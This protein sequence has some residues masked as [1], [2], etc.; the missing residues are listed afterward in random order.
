[1]DRAGLKPSQM[2]LTKSSSRSP[3]GTST[4]KLPSS[5]LIL[6]SGLGFQ[7]WAAPVISP[8][9]ADLPASSYSASGQIVHPTLGRAWAEDAFNGGYWNAGSQGPDWI[10]ADMGSTQT[11]SMVKIQYSSSATFSISGPNVFI[12]VYLSDEPIG[13]RWTTLTPVATAPTPFDR[14][15]L[16]ELQFAP[17]S[18]RYLQIVANYATYSWVALGDTHPRQDW[19]DP[20]SVPEPRAGLLLLAGLGLLG[21]G[22]RRLRADGASAS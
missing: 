4:R 20:I 10:Q 11:L 6:A 13:N 12:R 15:E 7:A 14:G 16:F 21:L 9:A 1:M 19:V 22:R 17:T 8:F 18:G 2:N 3:R 5:A